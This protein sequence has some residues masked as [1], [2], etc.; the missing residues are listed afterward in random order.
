MNRRTFVATAG[1]VGLVGLAGCSAYDLGE[2]ASL[3]DEDEIAEVEAQHGEGDPNDDIAQVNITN[4]D[5]RGEDLRVDIANYEQ[6]SELRV[7][8]ENTDTVTTEITDQSP[9]VSIYNTS[10]THGEVFALGDINIEVVDEDGETLDTSEVSYDPRI[11]L[12]IEPAVES[13]YM[14]GGDTDAS[15]LFTFVNDGSGPTTIESVEV[16]EGVDSISAGGRAGQATFVRPDIVVGAESDVF[17]SVGVENDPDDELYLPEGRSLFFGADSIFVHVGEEPE[18]V[19]SFEQQFEVAIRTKHGRDYLFGVTVQF[20][21]GIVES[22]YQPSS[23][24]SAYRFE[25]FDIDVDLLL[26]P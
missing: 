10:G 20:S 2:T 18:S 3:S 19:E 25:E 8:A 15:A 24:E 5:T 13:P 16:F 4:V 22:S 9:T 6:A 17:E 26:E 21:G 23:D 1:S 7:D 11:D 12:K 14:S